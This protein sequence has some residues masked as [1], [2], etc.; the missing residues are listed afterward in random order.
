MLWRSGFLACRKE[1]LHSNPRVIMLCTISSTRLRVIVLTF[2]K[3]GYGIL[4]WLLL[5]RSVL[6]CQEK[7]DV[8]FSE[9][10]HCTSSPTPVGLS[11]FMILFH[12]VTLLSVFILPYIERSGV[13]VRRYITFESDSVV[14][15][16]HKKDYIV[17]RGDFVP[18]KTDQ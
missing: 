3:W 10:L 9:G 1:S 13:R 7:H 12:G 18:K 6:L 16:K 15:W 4:S 11:V 2:Y 17:L 5:H 14:K 8:T